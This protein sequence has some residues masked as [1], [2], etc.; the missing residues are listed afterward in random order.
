MFASVTTWLICIHLF[1]FFLSP[2]FVG[3]SIVKFLVPIQE[4]RQRVQKLLYSNA[5]N[6]DSDELITGG[7]G[8]GGDENG[9]NGE[10]G[11]ANN[12]GD[13]PQE[14]SEQGPRHVEMR[15]AQTG[16]V[17]RLFRSQAE[18]ARL[19][20]VSQSHISKSC[21]SESIAYG[22]KW[23][24]Y[25]G[26]IPVYCTFFFLSDCCVIFLILLLWYNDCL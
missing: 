18:V 6:V 1:S 9:G 23:N 13:E 15:H 19:L 21:A 8:G 3:N 10:N 7:G 16:E 5:T 24:I 26:P 25:D 11:E 17:L 20:G 14:G 22:Y 12:P 2:F 4:L